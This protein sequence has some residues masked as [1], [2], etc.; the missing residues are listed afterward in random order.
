VDFILTLPSGGVPSTS[1]WK[2]DRFKTFDYN[3]SDMYLVKRAESLL[4]PGEKE[5]GAE[6]WATV[7]CRYGSLLLYDWEIPR[8]GG[9]MSDR[10]REF[11]SESDG[12]RWVFS[13]VGRSC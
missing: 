7:S 8:G 11:M 13:A 5:Y 12:W 3:A 4:M 1:L 2:I 6:W 10:D 9:L